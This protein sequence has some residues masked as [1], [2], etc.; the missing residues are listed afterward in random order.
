MASSWSINAGYQA[1]INTL[2]QMKGLDINTLTLDGDPG[3]MTK[4]AFDKIAEAYGIEI[5]PDASL[6]DQMAAIRDLTQTTEFQKELTGMVESG[7]YGPARAVLAFANDDPT[8]E[9]KGT[10]F[11]DEQTK[12]ALQQYTDAEKTSIEQT[13]Q[14]APEPAKAPDP[15]PQP[16]PEPEPEPE[17]APADMDR[18]A[19]TPTETNIMPANFDPAATEAPAKPEEVQADQTPVIDTDYVQTE[20]DREALREQ[21]QQAATDTAALEVE[22]DKLETQIYGP[23]DE[24]GPGVAITGTSPLDFD[25][26][27][28]HI[29]TTGDTLANL[30][31]DAPSG[32]KT[33]VGMHDGLL[34]AEQ[35]LDNY[36]A[37]PLE[38][39]TERKII[40][41]VGGVYGPIRQEFENGVTE[42]QN[43][44][45]TAYAEMPDDRKAEV[46]AYVKGEPVPTQEPRKDP[47][48]IEPEELQEGGET[49]LDAGRDALRDAFSMSA[50]ASELDPSTF[51]PATQEQLEAAIDQSEIVIEDPA[52]TDVPVEQTTFKAVPGALMGPFSNAGEAGPRSL[53]D[54]VTLKDDAAPE[55][56]TVAANNPFALRSGTIYG[57]MAALSTGTEYSADGKLIKFPDM[58]TGIEYMAD[59]IGSLADAKGG[60]VTMETALYNYESSITFGTSEQFRFGIYEIDQIAANIAQEL[61]YETGHKFDVNNPQQYADV[62]KGVS[63]YANAQADAEI[64]DITTRG[65]P[66]S[67][68]DGFNEYTGNEPEPAPSQ[69]RSPLISRNYGLGSG[70]TGTA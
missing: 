48:V 57:D 62:L 47:S 23:E 56:E 9:A 38:V 68:V 15:E 42:A 54:T 4:A 66:Q 28:V 27:L 17:P 32:Y 40:G 25:A 22:A 46:A 12:A 3:R 16:E 64:D 61:G 49:W 11:N 13:A 2:A 29:E 50:I 18:A 39:N 63:A 36:L 55:L 1:S 5:S 20:A 33:L 21:A 30:P 45:M 59:Q 10:G 35:E 24:E 14:A 60:F 34:A 65:L 7:E 43:G 69:E 52:P 6:Q 53:D 41:A 26:V 31:A 8:L 51:V 37:F 19:A 44:F 70:P 67:F 58:E